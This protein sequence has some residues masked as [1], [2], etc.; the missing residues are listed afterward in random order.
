M[1]VYKGTVWCM[2][3]SVFESK[4]ENVIASLSFKDAVTKTTI[5]NVADLFSIDVKEHV[6]TSFSHEK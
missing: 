5:D 3:I 6:M 4:T 2:F 1:E